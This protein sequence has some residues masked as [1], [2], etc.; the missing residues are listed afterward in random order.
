MLRSKKRWEKRKKWWEGRRDSYVA[1]AG[2]KPMT[3][4]PQ[5]PPAYTKCKHA[6]SQLPSFLNKSQPMYSPTIPLM[7]L[8]FL[9]VLLVLFSG[10]MVLHDS[11]S[12]IF[13]LF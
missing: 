11:D 13:L 1:E 7:Q 8:V 9:L 5:F 4:L 6:P 12:L 3:T 2:C 10:T